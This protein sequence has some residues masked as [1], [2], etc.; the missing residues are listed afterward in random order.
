MITKDQYLVNCAIHYG[1]KSIVDITDEDF[2]GM[3]TIDYV[4][5]GIRELSE[6]EFWDRF[7]RVD[8]NVVCAICGR[9]YYD[10]P[11][12]T[13]LN[14]KVWNGAAPERRLCN[15]WFGHL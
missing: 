13:R 7:H 11:R 6:E 1:W 8:G 12:E 4:D 5:D 2:A 10:H 3:Q 14:H 9:L 15:G